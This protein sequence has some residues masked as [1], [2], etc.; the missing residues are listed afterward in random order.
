M[1]T[2]DFVLSTIINDKPMW[3][4]KTPDGQLTLTEDN[5]M[6][7]VYSD[8]EAGFTDRMKIIKKFDGKIKVDFIFLD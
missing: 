8:S 4:S 1:K 7:G 6:V 5:K 2:N 3:A